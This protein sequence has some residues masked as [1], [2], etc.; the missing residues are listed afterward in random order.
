M[1]TKTHTL[2]NWNQD[3]VQLKQNRHE[4]IRAG[5]TSNNLL[6]SGAFQRW[7]GELKSGVTEMTEYDTIDRLAGPRTQIIATLQE[8]F[9]KLPEG[10]ADA[11][12]YYNAQLKAG[13]VYTYGNCT[14]G[15][16]EYNEQTCIKF[17]AE[18]RE[19]DQYK[20]EGGSNKNP[21]F[22]IDNV[23]S[24]HAQIKEAKIVN[25][26][27]R[28]RRQ[29]KTL[30]QKLEEIAAGGKNA[31]KYIDVDS[32]DAH[33]LGAKFVSPSKISKLKLMVDDA[34]ALPIV[35]SSS[36]KFQTAMEFLDNEEYGDKNNIRFFALYEAEK[37]KNV[38][39]EDAPSSEGEITAVPTGSSPGGIGFEPVS[40]NVI[41]PIGSPS[42]TKK[43]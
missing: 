27:G 14:N 8:N 31:D 18:L 15:Q 36:A 41:N 16:P 19:L 38:D 22:N 5:P 13:N 2:P 10:F 37:T 7:K 30:V 23:H 32:I 21:I 24:I 12:E 33:G 1:A 26:G 40:A 39:K 35:A 6:I 9:D 11:T 4:F 34:S 29:G 28:R 20:K 17:R 3:I 43:N 25:K 42:L